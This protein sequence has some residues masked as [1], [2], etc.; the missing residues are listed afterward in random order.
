MLLQPFVEN[1][2]EHG[3]AGLNSGELSI[4]FELI[5]NELHVIIEDNGKGFSSAPENKTHIS[6][7]TQ[8]I[9][10]RLYLLNLKYKSKARF[11]IQ[12]KTVGVRADVY[13]PLMYV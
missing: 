2:I 12:Q 11:T 6:R 9:Q 4:H 13:L 8:I 3:F 10:D 7:A 5:D 1:S